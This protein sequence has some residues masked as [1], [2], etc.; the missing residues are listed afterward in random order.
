MHVDAGQRYVGQ[1]RLV[2][3]HPDTDGDSLRHG[4]V[5]RGLGGEADLGPRRH[6][7]WEGGHRDQVQG[8]GPGTPWAEAH[9]QAL[10]AGTGLPPGQLHQSL[11]LPGTLPPGSLGS[12]PPGPLEG[13][14]VQDKELPAAGPAAPGRGQE[15][16]E[17]AQ[18]CRGQGQQGEAGEEDQADHARVLAA[19][20]N[21]LLG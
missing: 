21:R 19:G 1:P 9:L 3:L 8:A 10:E 2:L 18:L 11:Q 12:P 17:E 13:A 7:H 15:G 14:V 16:L 20:R 5:Q 6:H 4:L